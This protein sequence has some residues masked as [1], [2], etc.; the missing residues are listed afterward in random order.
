[1]ELEMINKNDTLQQSIDEQLKARRT[2]DKSVLDMS[3]Q[4]QKLSQQN[5]GLVVEV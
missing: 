5:D 2:S 4:N 1:M 3:V